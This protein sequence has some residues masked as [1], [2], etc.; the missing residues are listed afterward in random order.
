MKKLICVVLSIVMLTGA[1][2]FTA[3]AQT[4][5]GGC[6]DGVFWSLNVERGTLTIS[7]KGE[8]NDYFVFPI[9]S[10]SK[11]TPWNNYNDIITYV[12]VDEDIT[13]IGDFA[14][15]HLPVLNEV[16]IGS[17]V[18]SIGFSSFLDC[19]S[20]EWIDIPDSV[21]SVGDYCFGSCSSLRNIHLGNKITSL[22]NNMFKGC[23]ALEGIV[24]PYSV[25]E[26]H[27]DAFANCN[28]LKQIEFQGE[29]K[30]NDAFKSFEKIERVDVPDI[31]TLF[32][33][34]TYPIFKPGNNGKVYI[35]GELL[36]EL[37]VPENYSELP[38]GLLTNNAGLVS[39][40][41]G[42]R[43]TSIPDNAF[44]G[45]V[46]LKK[47]TIG[48]NVSSIGENAFNGC[49]S[50]KRI[51][52]PKNVT[53]L[54]SEAFRDCTSLSKVN[55][56]NGMTE[57]N[58]SI[59]MGCSS[60]ERFNIPGTVQKIVLFDLDT[61]IENLFVPDSITEDVFAIGLKTVIEPERPIT[62]LRENFNII[63]YTGSKAE[64]YANEKEINFIDVEKPSIWF[65]DISDDAWYSKA[66]GY[67]YAKNYITGIDER[68]F[69]PDSELT[70]E[71]F[72]QILFSMECVD[73]DEYSGNTGFTDAPAGKW[74][75]AAVKWAK[76]EGLSAGIGNGEFGI[77]KKI[78]R[79]QLAKFLQTYFEYKD[80]PTYNTTSLSRY[81]DSDEISAWA[82]SSMKWA[83]AE[84][85]ISGVTDTTLS[86]KS[87][88]T[89][90]Q[91]AQM[92]KVLTDNMV[93]YSTAS[94]G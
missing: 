32:S 79:E 64:K 58:G 6:G 3:S 89:R 81:T 35:N 11:E 87:T 56:E 82:V 38:V 86:P 16:Y 68:E 71:Q 18:T 34:S 44:S 19:P 47:I 65:D 42:D 46:N 4:V 51:C 33:I 73:G 30:T 93:K 26:I 61:N 27:Q 77:G 23:E 28:E 83:I 52:I 54:K 20:L 8:M 90:A 10:L 60:L 94:E 40:D 49:I 78:T 1:F 80:Y 29:I 36:D 66:V 76:E 91:T 41:T 21:E 31:E 24:I 63:G 37:T 5:E 72:V 70:R 85:L 9:P 15:S 74:Y 39:L 22:S 17:N 7:G 69:S 2:A 62:K 43:I 88:A 53:T 55:I 25:T 92:I 14:F 84:K 13:H 59:F 45:C 48:K 75:S 57:L 50:L 12:I 67:C